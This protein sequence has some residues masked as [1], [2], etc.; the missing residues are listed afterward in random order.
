[1]TLEEGG[2][3]G[4]SISRAIVKQ[5]DGVIRVDSEIAIR[6]RSSRTWI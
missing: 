2:L 5:H 3:R 6:P 4:L 1:M